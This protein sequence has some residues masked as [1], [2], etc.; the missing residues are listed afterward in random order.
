MSIAVL[1]SHLRLACVASVALIDPKDTVC[2]QLEN[3]KL[4]NRRARRFYTFADNGGNDSGS[5]VD[6]LSRRRFLK[7][8]QGASFEDF[9][10]MESGSSTED[11]ALSYPDPRLSRE[12][13]WSSISSGQ[14]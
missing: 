8:K 7:I 13:S 1:Q 11:D 9:C 4:N 10:R 12:L 6:L 5:E 14:N 3:Q 2:E